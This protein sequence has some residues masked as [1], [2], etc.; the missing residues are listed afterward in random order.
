MTHFDCKSDEK[1]GM[2]STEVFPRSLMLA[3]FYAYIMMAHLKWQVACKKLRS[4]R[5][6]LKLLEAVLKTGNRM[7]D[8][9]YRGG[10]QAFKLDTLLKLSDVK[11]T[12]GKTTLLHFVVQEI[13]R[14]EGIRAV[15][16][17]RASQSD[18]SMKTDDFAE[19]FTE[20]SAE[21]YRILGLQVV[22]GLSSELEDVK[23]AAFID[24]DGLTATVSKLNQSLRKTKDFLNA[25]MKSRDEES[26][27]HRTLANFVEC[28]EAD[29]S[30]LLGEEKRIMTLV[31]SAADYFHGK[32]GK[33]EGLRLFAIVRDFL[34]MLDKACKEVRDA[35]MKTVI[36]TPKKEAPTLSSSL[37]IH[38]QS[39]DI[40][41]R[42]FPAIMERRI[43]N[44]SSDD[45]SLSP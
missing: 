29:I 28:V 43:G 20:E 33:D 42:L 44:S 12:D 14:S 18:S 25:D 5:L 9:T 23:R 27:F 16:T 34:R 45:E 35:G 21:H 36:R 6:F 32:A 3:R 2:V 13:I 1:S 40:R 24:A 38:Q 10:A 17:E 41:Q 30:G 26:E 39:A 11:G 8:G 4:S 37:E 22:S 7:N 31:K 19:D 15:R